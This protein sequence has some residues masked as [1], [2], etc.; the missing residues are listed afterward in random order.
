MSSDSDAPAMPSM[1]GMSQMFIMLP[2]LYLMKNIDFTD[3]RNL[4]L[5][6][7]GFVVVQVLIFV[8]R[9]LI[10]KRITSNADQTK[11]TV[12]LP[13]TPTGFTSPPTPGEVVDT[14]VLE[15]DNG[16]FK[17]EFNQAI[18]TLG[19]ISVIH[20]YWESP[21]PLF[22][23]IF[24]APKTFY[25]TPL[26]QLYLMGKTLARPFKEP[27]NPLQQLMGGAAKQEA[28]EAGSVT[29][30][31]NEVEEEEEQEEQ[32]QEESAA[33]D[34]G[35]EEEEQV[36]GPTKKLKGKRSKKCD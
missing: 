9:G 16:A 31:S 23:Q 5:V 18:M 32:E 7:V 26:C 33:A 20:F 24:M 25:S 17:K 36:A 4:L 29:T 30:T 11:I 15:Y 22:L 12:Q 19:I 6:R 8:C 28:P 10:W 13:S 1:E 14:T 21:H 2:A 35:E 3:E 27:E 34:A